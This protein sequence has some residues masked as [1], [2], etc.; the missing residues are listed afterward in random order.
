MEK[1]QKNLSIYIIM[2][3][4]FSGLIYIAL[5]EGTRFDHLMSQHAASNLSPI[6]AFQHIIVA[7]L[8][9]SVMILLMQMIVIL[10]TCWIFSFLFKKIG[11]PGVIGEIVA[12]IIL[13]PS[14]LGY[15]FPEFSA[16]LFPKSSLV[17]IHLISQIGL[18]FFM[19]VIG[20]EVDFNTL[21]NKINETLV[22]S[23]AGI[24]VPFLLGILS[25]YWVFEKYAAQ[26]TSFLPFALFMGISMRITA[27]PVLARIIQ[28]RD[29]T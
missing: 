17:N 4:L 3:I 18:I 2:M 25:S 8:S 9:S 21:K 10:V 22:I 29:I 23:H 20:L 13:G 24:L 12:G 27:F 28:E 26:T 15:L 6:T 11:Q 19:F 1:K 7:N 14:L 5:K 16:F